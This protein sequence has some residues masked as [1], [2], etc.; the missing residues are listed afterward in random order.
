MTVEHTRKNGGSLY[1]STIEN[2]HGYWS[3][4]RRSSSDAVVPLY[5][6]TVELAYTFSR[7]HVVKRPSLGLNARVTSDA[8]AAGTSSSST[9]NVRCVKSGDK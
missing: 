6:E 4:M 9:G 8:T 7:H 1:Q 5:A 2:D 3:K